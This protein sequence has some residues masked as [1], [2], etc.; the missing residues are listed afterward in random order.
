MNSRLKSF[1]FGMIAIFLGV[2]GT[3]LTAEILLRFL[4]YYQG[5]RAQS[6]SRENPVFRFEPN[7]TVTT[8]EGWN[9]NLANTVHINNAGF[10]NQQDYDEA[11]TSPLLAVIGDSY[12][13][14]AIVPYPETVYGRLAN[15]LKDNGGRVY[16]FAA[17][18]MGLPQYL[19]WARHARD[20]YRPDLYLFNI[21]SN[22]FAESLHAHGHSPGGWRFEKGPEG[23]GICQLTPYEPSLT[24]RLLRHSALAMYLILNVRA[25]NAI[26]A[27]PIAFLNLGD[28]DK[29]WVANVEAWNP[30]EV[31]IQYK[32]A[33]DRF[34]EFVP[35][36]TGVGWDRV[37]FS[38]D[39][40]RPQMY[41]GGEAYAFARKSTWG[42]MR[43]YFMERARAYG[44]T[45]IDLDPAFRRAYAQNGERFEFP[46]D[47]H[48][49]GN[50]HGVL[51]D[52]LRHTDS[53]R[54]VFS[55][56]RQKSTGN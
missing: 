40:F 11:L 50:G 23:Q 44:A 32:W 14:A 28:K 43:K 20:T 7:R 15:T 9:F 51:A 16:S 21:I 42:I 1:L 12:I 2:A 25:H 49:N 45:I 48:W 34:L 6:V 39:G 24:R 46:A 53:F 36:Y 13:E 37:V 35:E 41:E 17:A 29:R 10:A 38:F 8:S 27:D 26:T 4:P 54:A 47:S 30:D 5:F 3:L 55:R 56:E 22:D 19:I 33:V 52:A 18:G 31:I